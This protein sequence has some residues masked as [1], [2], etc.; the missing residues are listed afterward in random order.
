MAKR[1]WEEKIRRRNG[2]LLARILN[3]TTT[4]EA[5]TAIDECCASISNVP[6]LD[7]YIERGM[8][9]AIGVAVTPNEAM[10]IFQTL[11]C[12]TYLQS[13]EKEQL[14]F[15]KALELC[16]YKEDIEDEVMKY[17]YSNYPDLEDRFYFMEIFER[18]NMLGYKP[19]EESEE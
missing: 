14:A 15:R 1:S 17:F 8:A 4:K 13:L 9:R 6:K 10:G 2:R 3:A 19:Q 18:G 5:L 7:D 12:G 16:K 11:R